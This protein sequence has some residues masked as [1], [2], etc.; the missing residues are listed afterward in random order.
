VWADVHSP[1]THLYLVLAALLVVPGLGCGD[2]ESVISNQLLLEE[3][4][5]RINYV[6]GEELLQ[7]YTYWYGEPVRTEVL[8]DG[9]LEVTTLLENP[10]ITGRTDLEN[11]G[12][13]PTSEGPDGPYRDT[14]RYGDFENRW[15][16]AHRD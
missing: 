8:A 16:G 12:Y 6:S 5:I 3:A 14:Q 10:P 9:T 13:G 4:E 15:I 11:I 1:P 7:D 2:A